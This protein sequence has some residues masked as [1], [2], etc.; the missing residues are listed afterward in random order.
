MNTITY[1]RALQAML[2]LWKSPSDVTT[3]DCHR[4]SNYSSTSDSSTYSSRNESA[5]YNSTNDSSI[6]AAT[7]VATAGLFVMALAMAT[8]LHQVAAAAVGAVVVVTAASALLHKFRSRKSRSRARHQSR[9]TDSR[10]RRQSWQQPRKADFY[11]T[12]EYYAPFERWEDAVMFPGSVLR[13][14]LLDEG[15]RLAGH[16]RLPPKVARK[17]PQHAMSSKA[18]QWAQNILPG[19]QPDAVQISKQLKELSQQNTGAEGGLEKGIRMDESQLIAVATVLLN[20]LA[21]LHGPPGTG[22]TTTI[23]AL[24]YCLRRML[25]YKGD[26]LVVAQSNVAVDNMLEGAMRCGE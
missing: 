14:A 20:P 18:V 26:M 11:S 10:P 25:R 13:D 4:R 9:S 24:L 17:G 19:G 8:G 7:A 15:T 1:E 16:F 22:K 21:L 3:E 5:N 23:V 12:D 2:A 6:A